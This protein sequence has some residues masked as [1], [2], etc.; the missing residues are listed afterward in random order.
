MIAPIWPFGENMNRLTWRPRGEVMRELDKSYDGYLDDIDQ[1][2]EV[3]AA[4]YE[5][6]SFEVSTDP[7]YQYCARIDYV[8]PTV[9]WWSQH[10]LPTREAAREWCESMIEQALAEGKR[11]LEIS[12]KFA[13]GLYFLLCDYG[14]AGSEWRVV[15]I[16][17]D[18]DTGLARVWYFGSEVDS[19][20]DEVNWESLTPANIVAPDG[21]SIR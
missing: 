3:E 14:S 13:P 4:I 9:K 11:R 5:E 20:V 19:D 2:F 15:S 7:V 16:T 10:N 8:S 1:Q 17:K 12:A 6:L 21:S 18:D